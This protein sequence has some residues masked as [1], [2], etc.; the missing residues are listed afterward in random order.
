LYDYGQCTVPDGLTHVTAIAAGAWH[1][2]AL[3][4]NGTV[5]AW[6]CDLDRNPGACNV[7]SRLVGVTA[8]AA[9][10][11]QS[12]VLAS[13]RCVVPRVI[14]MQLPA[15][16]RKLA[17]S[18]CRGG[19]IRRISARHAS[20]TVLFQARLAGSILRDGARIGLIVGR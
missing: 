11:T 14:G 4:R 8:I 6:G 2:L 9:G 5:V 16:E 1:S 13:P 7:P 12:L 17:R 20:E 19:T 15:A 3:R 18:R 10:G